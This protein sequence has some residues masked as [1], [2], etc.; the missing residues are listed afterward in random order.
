MYLGT[1]CLKYATIN[2][3]KN[4]YPNLAVKDDRSVLYTLSIATAVVTFFVNELRDFVIAAVK[5]AIKIDRDCDP[6]EATDHIVRA[7]YDAIER[8]GKLSQ[9][10]IIDTPT[11]SVLIRALYHNPKDVKYQMSYVHVDQT[12]NTLVNQFHV[13]ATNRSSRM[14]APLHSKSV[15]G[16]LLPMAY[17]AMK[18]YCRDPDDDAMVKKR[19]H[20][21]FTL[22]FKTAGFQRMPGPVAGK[23]SRLSY[24]HWIPFESISQ[25]SQE[26]LNQLESSS[27]D[28]ILHPSHQLE[29]KRR[30]SWTTTHFDLN[31]IGEYIHQENPPTNFDLQ[32]ASLPTA[33][34][35]N[36]YV[37]ETFE[38]VFRQFTMKNPIHV[39]ILMKGIIF[40]KLAWKARYSKSVPSALMR[41]KSRGQKPIVNDFVR[42]TPW[43]DIGS[44]GRKGPKG[45][46]DQSPFVVMVTVYTIA[47][48][49]PKSP[50]RQRMQTN[51]EAIGEAWTAKFSTCDRILL[52]S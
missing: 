34:R 11:T 9:P 38:Y 19:F 8:W 22:S 6:S 32:H 43:T 10:F 14:I 20:S 41:A 27:E 15:T 13:V 21:A 51:R 26:L 4:F 16:R 31:M 39:L 5:D 3:P 24:L 33:N 50:L 36:G 23:P 37:L 47:L 48:L 18:Q 2:I 7:R 29:G 42:Q 44:G 1:I 28:F 17:Q 40:S 25:S 12:I 35:N 30:G 49:D 45:F 46:T 52:T